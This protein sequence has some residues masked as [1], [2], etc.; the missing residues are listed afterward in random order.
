MDRLDKL[1]KCPYFGMINP[2]RNTE[3]KC[4]ACRQ[5][6]SKTT[7][8]FSTVFG[9]REKMSEFL[10][11]HCRYIEPEGCDVYDR[12]KRDERTEKCA[13]ETVGMNGHSGCAGYSFTRCRGRDNCPYY[14]SVSRVEEERKNTLLRISL[15][16]PIKREYIRKKY[17][18]K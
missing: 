3:I 15:L 8:E 5:D 18:I 13:M 6:K 11:S 10:Y 4:T 14:K 16:P 2:H 12:I 17:K 7:Y 9:S 1:A